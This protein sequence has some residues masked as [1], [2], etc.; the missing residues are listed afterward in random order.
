MY[1]NVLNYASFQFIRFPPYHRIGHT[2]QFTFDIRLL[3]EF[4]Y[5]LILAQFPFDLI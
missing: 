3:R 2:V 1:P 4:D 5:R